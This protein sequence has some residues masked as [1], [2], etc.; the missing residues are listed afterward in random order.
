MSQQAALFSV[1]LH[2]SQAIEVERALT[3]WNE[4][5][6]ADAKHTE[7]FVNYARRHDVLL[8]LTLAGLPH[9]YVPTTSDVLEESQ[10]AFL[11]QAVIDDRRRAG[12][13][14]DLVA[15]LRRISGVADASVVIAPAVEGPLG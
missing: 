6:S 13:E 11:P 3:I 9:R 14:G 2:P 8:R 15:S 7:I 10:S 4:P 5:F 12:I 1:P